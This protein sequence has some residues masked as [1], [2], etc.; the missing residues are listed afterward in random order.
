MMTGADH[1]GTSWLSTRV[2]PKTCVAHA[3]PT[4]FARLIKKQSSPAQCTVTGAIATRLARESVGVGAIRGSPQAASESRTSERTVLMSAGRMAHSF[5]CLRGLRALRRAAAVFA[6][7]VTLPPSRPSA[8]AAGFFF[9][10]RK[11][12]SQT[13]GYVKGG[14]S[15]FVAVALLAGALACGWNSLQAQEK[16]AVPV[17]SEVGKLRIITAVQSV[18][19]AELRAQQARERLASVLRE[20]QRPGFDLD[21]DTWTYAPKKEPGKK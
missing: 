8:T 21:L 9:G 3:V 4:F 17:L 12:Y 1:H 19:I 18:E 11:R 2:V 14:L 6:G 7:L 16:P 13:L 5:F 15:R 10:M 20:A